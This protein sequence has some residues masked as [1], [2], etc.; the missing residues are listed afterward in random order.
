MH[1]TL[2][3]I[4]THRTRL[5]QEIRERESLLAAFDM[6][7]KYAAANRHVPALVNLNG[8]IST[9]P[10]IENQPETSAI[11]APADPPPAPV[12]RY[13]H[14]ELQ[15]IS[16]N[17][18]GRLGP[19]VRWAIQRMPEDYSVHDIEKLLRKEGQ[20][21]RPSQISV[22]VSRLKERGEIEEVQPGRGPIPA[23]FRAPVSPQA[24]ESENA[25]TASAN[26]TP[27]TAIEDAARHIGNTSP[28]AET[29][30]RR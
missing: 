12:K 28:S 16:P 19:L 5:Q 2:D 18:Q 8:L 7:E 11:P 25:E 30:W 29:I 1:L 26:E 3:E 15:A 14:P 22:V 4:A 6:V 21:I 17:A 10:A 13:V 9:L 23:L 20:G 27:A 24:D